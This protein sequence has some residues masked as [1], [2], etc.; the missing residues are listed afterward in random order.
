MLYQ[1]DTDSGSIVLD[2]IDR[3]L[4]DQEYS[5]F[6]VAKESKQ[7]AV[8]P[9]LVENKEEANTPISTLPEADHTSAQSQAL[10]PEFLKKFRSGYR[11]DAAQVASQLRE[12]AVTS[13][14]GILRQAKLLLKMKER[15]NRKEWGVWLRE[16][17]GWFGN[18]AT[19][20]LQIA[21]VFR[22]F[23]P[24]V[25]RKLEPFTILKL[26]TKRYAPLVARLREELAITSDLIQNFIKEVIP[27]QSRRKR[28]APNYD[29]AVLKQRLN[30]EDGTFYF[31]LNVNL[32][33]K[34]GSWLE[35]RLENCTVGQVLEQAA[36]L[37]KQAEERRHERSVLEGEIEQ[38]VRERVEIAEFALKQE[39][40][41]LKAQLQT[42]ANASVVVEKAIATNDANDDQASSEGTTEPASITAPH[43]TVAAEPTDEVADSTALQSTEQEAME[44]AIAPF[45]GH[46]V[47]QLSEEASSPSLEPTTAGPQDAVASNPVEELA[48]NSAPPST[49]LPE[50]VKPASH[51]EEVGDNSPADYQISK[52]PWKQLVQIRGAE[53]QIQ[54]L[55]A[56]IKKFTSDLAT[57]RLDRIVANQFRDALNNRQKLRSTKIGQI[58]DVADENG[59]KAD[60]EQLR[61]F[62]KVVLAPEY[63]SALLRLAF[64]WSEVAIVVGNDRDQLLLAVKA[65]NL[66]EKHLLIQLLS[67]HLETEA[68]ALEQINWIPKNLLSRA[69]SNFTFRLQRIKQSDNLVDEPEMEYLSGCKF[70]SVQKLGDRYEQWILEF[71]GNNIP[72]FD[73]EQFVIEN[74]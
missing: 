1:Q 74:S 68:N 21:K 19:P 11:D 26:R 39:I 29:E 7:R 15:L 73:R 70:V 54:E 57:P 13:A 9:A 23:D 16:V 46:Q 69:L 18:E 72:V 49:E 67:S 50:P 8:A 30:A 12:I 58:I 40:A 48:T 65:W 6:H 4:P 53:V 14:E 66:E 71:D 10:T 32:G 60:Y 41:D 63:A 36:A 3:N 34:Q 24:A 52:A 45:T 55:D 47:C 51:P 35:Q 2:Y 22:E 17:L 38:R 31:S 61:S 27:K 28:A 5:P 37:E 33:D 59:I 43:D 42:T 20:Y 64:S 56:H 62:G 44:E 25:F